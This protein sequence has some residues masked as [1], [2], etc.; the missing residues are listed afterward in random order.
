MTHRPLRHYQVYIYI[1]DKVSTLKTMLLGWDLY[2]TG[3]YGTYFC[4][5]GGGWGVSYD[6]YLAKDPVTNRQHRI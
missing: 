4:R 3:L 5:G 2:D 6:T 1:P